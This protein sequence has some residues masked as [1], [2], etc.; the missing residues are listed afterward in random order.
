[1][2]ARL[3]L[4]SG[5]LLRKDRRNIF[6]AVLLLGLTVLGVDKVRRFISYTSIQEKRVLTPAEVEEE[7]RKLGRTV[8]V[9]AINY[10][11]RSHL[12][13]FRCS[14]E[15]LGIENHLRVVALDDQAEVWAKSA[16]YNV[17]ESTELGGNFTTTGD[18]KFGSADFNL[19]S[20]RKIGV[21][22]RELIAGNNVLFTDADMFWCSNAVEK[23]LQIAA[24]NPEADLLMQ[25]A[26]PR[27]LLNSGFYFAR[28][29][30]NSKMLFDELLKHEG[31]DENDQVIFNRVLCNK[32]FG[33]GVVHRLGD[34]FLHRK[35]RH[36]IGCKWNGVLA[37]V[38]D[39]EKYPTGGELINGEKIFHLS[40]A[41]LTSM[42]ANEEFVILHNNC[43]LSDRKT[44]RF[45][46][47]GFWYIS[48]DETTCLSKPAET[49]DEALRRCGM[50]KCGHSDFDGFRSNR[51]RNKAIAKE[52]D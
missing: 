38:L 10:A 48:D 9:T 6:F 11:F 25:S 44:A 19:L 18:A 50:P 8:I 5:K 45:I 2:A 20:K 14:L 39:R 41:N 23:V 7:R 29:G 34:S 37:Q 24:E 3:L 15:R 47:K 21:V 49:T 27:S 1:M 46:V 4:N 16:N 12:S 31:P 40:R 51:L 35:L 36:P 17:L 26:W 33:G 42:C 52:N 32:K 43:I 28:S 13:N 22:A 30:E